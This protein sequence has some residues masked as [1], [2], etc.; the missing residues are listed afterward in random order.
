MLFGQGLWLGPK[1]QK[2]KSHGLQRNVHKP[3]Y[4]VL[5]AFQRQGWIPSD[6]LDSQGSLQMLIRDV[7]SLEALH[8][9]LTWPDHYP[10]K[11]N[12]A[13]TRSQVRIP[14]VGNVRVVC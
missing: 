13:C 7:F 5:F 4:R 1:L 8:S 14:S 2:L 6:N 3:S 11:L 10:Y 12:I 9:F